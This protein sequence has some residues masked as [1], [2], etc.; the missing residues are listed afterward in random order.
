MQY[1][2]RTTVMV[3]IGE[4]VKMVAVGANHRGRGLV[5][6]FGNVPIC[7]MVMARVTTAP[8]HVLDQSRPV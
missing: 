7:A 8:A 2:V 1:V 3:K 5:V 4:F 6:R